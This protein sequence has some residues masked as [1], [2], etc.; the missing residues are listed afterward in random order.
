MLNLKRGAF[1]CAFILAILT[2]SCHKTNSGNHNNTDTIPSAGITFASP[3]NGPDS[4]Q[5]TIH[6]Y[7][8]SSII[9]ADEVFFNGKQATVLS[10]NDSVL[11]AVVPTLAG[12]GAIT[13]ILDDT[14]YTGPTFTYDTTYLA[15]NFIS[16]LTNPQ[17]LAFDGNGTL[18]VTSLPNNLYELRA[19]GNDITHS[20][21]L[22]GQ[23]EG[24]AVDGANNV[25]F[26]FGGSVYLFTPDNGDTTLIA[27]DSSSIFEGLAIDVN[28][29]LYAAS[30]EKMAIEKIT[31]QGTI[32]IIAS[33]LPNVS[34]VAVGPDKS[35]YAVCTASTSN[36]TS[37]TV[38][39]ITP[40]GQTITLA[41]NLEI[42][43]QA[44]I[45]VDPNSNCYITCN[46]NPLA[47]R[48]L[49]IKNGNPGNP[50]SIAGVY[51]PLGITR[52]STGNLY[53]VSEWAYNG[54]NYGDIVKLGPH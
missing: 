33:G 17:Y 12:S 16:F 34:G 8:F 53:V 7:G 28:G 35:V 14:I 19:D 23:I 25:Y 30:V 48:V 50:V 24:V 2:M 42:T 18:F 52:D 37:G 9:P 47:S 44:G 26:A 5:V 54:A 21:N 4:T 36:P 45:V 31:P 39:Q 41:S 20:W 1:I 46:G 15:S 13:L 22:P 3:L 49:E 27:I 40:G 43:A 11:V 10:A 6:G 38:V 32:T 29:D 51:D